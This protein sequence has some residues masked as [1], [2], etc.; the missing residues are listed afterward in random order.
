MTYLIF[1]VWYNKINKCGVVIVV[2]LEP[3]KSLRIKNK[4]VKIDTLSVTRRASLYKHN[5]IISVC[6]RMRKKREM[7]V[8]P[9]V[10][11]AALLKKNIL[12]L[13]RF[14]CDY[15]RSSNVS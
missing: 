11:K 7:D 2:G 8:V 6:N 5:I 1:N 14:G 3:L 9:G 15:F 12:T 10:I 4:R 13:G